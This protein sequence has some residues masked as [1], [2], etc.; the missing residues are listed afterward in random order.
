MNKVI[1][2][3]KFVPVADPEMTMS[4]QRELCQRLGL[5]GRIIISPHGINGTLGG[6]VK[7][8]RQYKAE[9]N[10]SACFKGIQYKWSEGNGSEF[11]KLCVKV[12]SELVAFKKA[13]EIKVDE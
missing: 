6:N 3:Y 13:D 11:P 12:K 7:G 4:L 9:M 5:K 1:L 8:L 2:Y 10:R